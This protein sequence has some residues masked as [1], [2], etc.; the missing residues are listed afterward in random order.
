ST[1]PAMPAPSNAMV[2]SVAAPAAIARG[3]QRAAA[4]TLDRAALERVLARAAE[5]QS[6]AGDDA[7]PTEG[8]TDQQLLDVGREV[9]LPV[10]YLRQ[11]LAEERTR[12]R[13]PLER[14]LVAQMA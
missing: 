4:V 3:D 9:G 13:V 5:L 7:E 11:A 14:G 6:A 2:P 12:V 10:T 8:L 1:L